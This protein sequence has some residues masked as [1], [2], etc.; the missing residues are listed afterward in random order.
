MSRPLAVL[1]ALIPTLGACGGHDVNANRPDPNAYSLR[2]APESVSQPAGAATTVAIYASE[3]NAGDIAIRV[4]DWGIDDPTVALVSDL[5]LT[6][7]PPTHATGLVTCLKAGRA[8]VTGN[9]TLDSDQRLTQTL[10][11]TCTAA[12]A[13]R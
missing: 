5:A 8:V 10:P 11:V 12:P 3:A 2:F 13:A 6:I 7:D 9:V 1:V 4:V